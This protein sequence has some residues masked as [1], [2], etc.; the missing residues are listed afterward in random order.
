MEHNKKINHWCV[1]CGT[2]YHACD[3]CS[4]EKT[5]TPW[6]SLT[7]TIG[8]YKVFMVLRDYKNN[9]ISREKAHELLSGLDLSDKESYKDNAK[10]VLSDIYMVNAVDVDKHV[11]STNKQRG[12]KPIQVETE[13]ENESLSEK[14]ENSEE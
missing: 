10:S 12:R 2:G 13:M 14:T 6:R 3:S 11:K 4:K 8:H 7:D 1:L 9:V 5:I